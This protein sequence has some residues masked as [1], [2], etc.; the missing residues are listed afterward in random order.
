[1]S[2]ALRA[3]PD[4][5]YQAFLYR[6]Y[7]KQS[8]LRDL[9]IKYKRS[10]LGYLWTMIHPLAMMAVLSI[11]FS[12]IV[13]IPVKD[14]AVF[15][16]SALLAWNYFGSTVMMSLHSI[17]QNARIFS[18]VPVPKYL[19]ILSISASNMV[20]LIL[21]LV[22]LLILMVIMGRPLP[23]SAL[24][25]PVLLVPLF[26]V[27][28]GL[29]LILAASNVFYDDTYHLTEV[30]LQALYFMTPVLYH[31]DLLPAELVRYLVLNPLFCQVEFFRSIFYDGVLPDAQNFA[32]SFAGS[33]L[34]LLLG[35]TI[36]RRTEDKFMYFV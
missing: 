15:L 25:F 17:R 18:Q 16:F 3:V 14:Y 6:E 30:G 24:F 27:T 4:F 13:R 5:F 23:P 20:N 29:S 22:P 28:V 21:A 32:L 31:R 34:I 26:M 33:F 35:L 7:L 9:R 11:V 1:M 19:A 10:V 2:A 12:H 8:V 36:F